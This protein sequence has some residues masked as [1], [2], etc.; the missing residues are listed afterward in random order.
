M[1][2]AHYYYTVLRVE[3]GMDINKHLFYDKKTGKSRFFYKTTEGILLNPLCFTEDYLICELE[4]ENRE[5][6]R[7]VLSE[8]ELKKLDAFSYDDNPFLVKCI[9]K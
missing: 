8:E 5:M 7:N 6:M 1:Q 2:N 3:P 9:F 4:Y